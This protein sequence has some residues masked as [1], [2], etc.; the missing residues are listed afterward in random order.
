MMQ[1]L[2]REF[3][4]GVKRTVE[5]DDV[6]AF[7]QTISG[8]RVQHRLPPDAH[9]G[10]CHPKSRALLVWDIIIRTVSVYFFWC[11]ALTPWPWL[12]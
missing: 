11:A 10:V 8:T 12:A 5:M 1:K 7:F 3:A 2:K 4:Q 6:I 9:W